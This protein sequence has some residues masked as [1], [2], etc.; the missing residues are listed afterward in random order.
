MLALASGHAKVRP[1]T[2]PPSARGGSGMGPM[3]AEQS[4]KDLQ[5]PGV[6][7]N[8]AAFEGG[9]SSER[10][11][12]QGLCCL[13]RCYGLTSG[14]VTRQL[15]VATRHITQRVFSAITFAP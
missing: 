14:V 4:R 3:S 6:E 1:P 10:T 11:G 7:V 15:M 8:R 5:G 13:I 9:A 2:I 12:M